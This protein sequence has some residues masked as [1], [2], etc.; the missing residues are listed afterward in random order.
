MITLWRDIT[1]ITLS[2]GTDR[3]LLAV[4]FANSVDPDQRSAVHSVSLRLNFTVNLA[5]VKHTYIL[6]LTNYDHR[7]LKKCG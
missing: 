4:A 3:P 7:T 1:V 5:K 6:N 2:I